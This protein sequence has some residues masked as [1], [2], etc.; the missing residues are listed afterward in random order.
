M[1][2]EKLDYADTEIADVTGGAVQSADSGDVIV[3]SDHQLVEDGQGVLR[4]R[5]SCEFNLLDD[6]DDLWPPE[7][8]GDDDTEEW[9][10]SRGVG[11]VTDE[12]AWSTR[13]DWTDVICI[14]DDNDVITSSTTTTAAAA[15]D[16]VTRRDDVTTAINETV[17]KC[18]ESCDKVL[19]RHST[20]IR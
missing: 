10:W 4:R 13:S 18:I 3:K 5:R 7:G 12:W 20:A 1:A 14:T 11:V 15:A 9:A 17:M 19:L 8:R 16:D 2:L 6:E